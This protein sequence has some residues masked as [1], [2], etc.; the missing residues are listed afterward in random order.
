MDLIEMY[1][2]THDEL[3]HFHEGS[4]EVRDIRFRD[5]ADGKELRVYLNWHDTPT[6]LDVTMYDTTPKELEK[7]GTFYEDKSIYKFDMVP[8]YDQ[9]QETFDEFLK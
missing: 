6:Y 9:Y 4:D 1:E 5:G 3:L 8:P 7:C 2:D